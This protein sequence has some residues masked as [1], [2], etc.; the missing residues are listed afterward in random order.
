M[1]VKR[2]TTELRDYDVFPENA[3]SAFSTPIFALAL[4]QIKNKMN[5]ISH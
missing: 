3:F 5:K 4:S 2:Y 1:L